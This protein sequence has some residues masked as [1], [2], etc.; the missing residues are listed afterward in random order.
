MELWGGEWKVLIRFPL[1]RPSV[2]V[3]VLAL[4]LGFAGDAAS[5][6]SVEFQPLEPGVSWTC[7]EDNVFTEIETVLPGTQL[8]NGVPTRVIETS[9]GPDDGTREFRTNDTNGL[10]THKLTTPG[11]EGGVQVFTPPVTLLPAVFEVGTRFSSAGSFAFTFTGFGTFP[12]TYSISSEVVGVEQ[13]VVPAGTFQALRVDLTVTQSATINGVPM[14][15]SSTESDW[16]VRN[17]GVVL[18]IGTIDGDPFISELVSTNL[19]LCGDVADDGFVGP[20]DVALFR[21]V[22][23]GLASFTSA[24]EAKC[25]VIDPPSSC[26]LLDLTMI[27]REIE[28]PLLAPGISQLCGAATGPR[29]R[30]ESVPTGAFDEIVIVGDGIESLGFGAISAIDLF[31]GGIKLDFIGPFILAPSPNGLSFSDIGDSMA[32]IANVSVN[33]TTT[34][35]GFDASRVS[36]TADTIEVDLGGLSVRN[37]DV[38]TLVVIT[39]P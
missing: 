39:T 26:G 1:V 37:G 14:V 15:M 25:T 4:N 33:P 2:L 5:F 17:L 22:L 18:S 16:G 36:F 11:P 31:D 10:R 21:E 9:G 20:E 8:V 38:V 7:L 12:G 19:E 32:P 6:T 23:A 29:I 3:L 35:A 24:G 30:I 27:R 28:G 13:V 34:V